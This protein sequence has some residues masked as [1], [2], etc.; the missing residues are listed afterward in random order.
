[1]HELDKVTLVP[2]NAQS[3]F[4]STERAPR[5]GFSPVASSDSGRGRE[6]RDRGG[7]REG[8]VDLSLDDRP[9]DLFLRLGLLLNIE[10][11]R[12]DCRIMIRLH[13]RLP[14]VPGQFRRDRLG[15]SDGGQAVQVPME[16]SPRLAR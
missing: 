5:P 16:P 4:T 2:S 1:M 7:R 12:T 6:G 15:R 11:L 10:R 9:L 14:L 13:D 3:V 8:T